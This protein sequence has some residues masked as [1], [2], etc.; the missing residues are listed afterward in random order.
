MSN[1][2]TG[3]FE[4]RVLPHKPDNDVAEAAGLTRMSLDK[5]FHGDLEATSK[6]E[7]LASTRRAP[8]DTSRW[9]ASPAHSTGV[10]AAS[11]CNTPRP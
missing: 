10:A 3:P 1:R 8:A 4:V 7:M 5:Q 6:G 9:N 2:A 11:C